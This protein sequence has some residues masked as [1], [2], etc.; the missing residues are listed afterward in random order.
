[1]LIPI[2]S[3]LNKNFIVLNLPNLSL[4]QPKT[5]RHKKNQFYRNLATLFPTRD[6]VSVKES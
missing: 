2:R 1:M 5:L 3:R 4:E 6:D